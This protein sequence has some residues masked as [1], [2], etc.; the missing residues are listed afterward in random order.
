MKH[1]WRKFLLLSLLML[2]WQASANQPD[3]LSAAK[4]VYRLWIGVPLPTQIASQL[5]SPQML[6]EINSNGYVRVAAQNG[7]NLTLFKQNGQIYLFAGHGSGYLVST[8]GHLV[9]NDHVANADVGEMAQL[10][11]PEVF[12]VRTIAPHLELISTQQIFSDS[13]KDLSLLQVHGLTGKPL[14]LAAEKFL[15]PTLPVFSIGF[16]GA[17]DDITSGFGFGDPNAY[18]QPVIAEGTLKRE[19]K[20]YENRSYWE[21]HAPIS[22]GNS[23]GPLV[24]RCG[25][26]VGTNE[27]AHKEQV[28]TVIAV[29]NSEL[30]PIL[31]SHNV[32]FT[33]IKNECVDSATAST[34]RQ[35]TLLYSGMGLLILLA[36]GGG[37]YLLRLKK[38]VKA[39]SNPP[40]NSQLIRRIVGAQQIQQAQPAQA[41]ISGSVTLSALCGGSNIVLPAG[42]PTIIGRSAPAS[43]IINQAQVSARHVQLLFDGRQV[44][45][46]DLGSTNGTYVNGSKITR[47]V[48][49]AGDVLQLTADENIARFSMGS[50]QAAQP[51]ITATL[52]PLS[53]G[54]PAIAL[55]LGQTVR[56][57]RSSGNDVVINRQ[58]I[59]GSHCRI[60][61]DAAG[62]VVLEDLQ[63]TNGT[64]VDSLEQRISRTTLRPGQT[65]YLANRDIAYQLT[66]S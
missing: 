26:V 48:L 24:N 41:G 38:Q 50:P 35:L 53:A 14:P 63:S 37:V 56:I 40:I 30:V 29:S 34:K 64:F 10:G 42:K 43:V 13:A 65:I 55:Y 3:V 2:P 6:S 51:R 9:T 5:V 16:P 44:Q 20:N 31:Q 33:Q 15:Q 46:E 52:Q 57:G 8:E 23:G 28:N 19:F 61:V 18:I 11:K 36:G 60:S 39:G 7:Q 12:V 54:L 45:V 62:N 21:H 58:Q 17:S 66:Q 27:G 32:K 25:Q 1:F 4:S 59:S 47:A 22:G 49:N